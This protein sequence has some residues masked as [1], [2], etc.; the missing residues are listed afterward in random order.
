MI[1]RKTHNDL[2]ENAHSTLKCNTRVKNKPEAG[3]Y[4]WLKDSAYLYLNIYERIQATKSRV[5]YTI[6]QLLKRGA[7]QREIARTIEV[8]VST[9]SREIKRNKGKHTYRAAY[10]HML[11]RERIEMVGK[12]TPYK[13]LHQDKRAGG[14][15]YSFCRHGLKYK[16]QRLAIP[17][18]NKKRGR[19]KSIL[20]RPE[21]ID[22]Q[23]RMGDMEMDLILGASPNEAILTMVDRKTDYI[24]IDLL[25]HGRKSKPLA[26]VVNK[27]LAFLKRRGQ[28]H[29][30]TTDNGGEFSTYRSVERSLGIPVYFARPYRSTDKPYIEHANA[31]MTIP[32]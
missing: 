23:G 5:K 27:R 32:T 7:S 18:N 19:Y 4:L 22:K 26:R 30:I 15:L 8:S 12:S 3:Y 2:Q 25:T 24:F 14:S 28:L 17:K 1:K 31:L 11:A 13:W 20:E 9:V 6:A 21:I 29:S 16:R 10:A